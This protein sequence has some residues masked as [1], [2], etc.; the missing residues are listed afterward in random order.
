MNPIPPAIPPVFLSH[1]S[2]LLLLDPGR[3]GAAWQRLAAELPRPRAI[4]AVSAHWTTRL[5]AVSAAP[6]PATIHD[7]YGFPEP[8]YDMEYA[9]PGAPELATEVARLIPGIH[10][11]TR[12]GLDHGAW[13]PLSLMY[14]QAEVPVIQLAVQPMADAAAHFEL[15]RRLAPLA[16]DGVLVLASGSLTHNL[17]E[18]RPDFAD[19]TALPHVAEFCDWFAER[20]AAGDTDALL[21]WEAQAPQARRA[22]PTAEHLLPLYVALGAA[23]AGAQARAAHRGYQF[24][25]LAMDAYVFGT[26]SA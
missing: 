21:A 24:G 10:V 23:G 2:P 6:A 12:R 15:G 20:L 4:L 8:L 7:F 14:P 26:A 25:A 5:P 18:M 1:G 13:A 9:P 22:H 11:D 19:D 3:T 17:G 16:Q